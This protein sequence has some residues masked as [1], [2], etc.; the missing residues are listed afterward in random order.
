LWGRVLWDRSHSFEYKCLSL[1]ILTSALY[2][3]PT[4][5]FSLE[6]A[7]LSEPSVDE[8]RDRRAVKSPY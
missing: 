4:H 1:H 2:L 3:L 6:T 7:L 8:Q 5:I